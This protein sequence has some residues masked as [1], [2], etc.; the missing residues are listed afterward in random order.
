M[1][2]WWDGT[3]GDAAHIFGRPQLLVKLRSCDFFHQL[4]QIYDM[5]VP[6]TWSLSPTEEDGKTLAIP[7]VLPP[8]PQ[9]NEAA[10]PAAPFVSAPDGAATVGHKVTFVPIKLTVTD[11]PPIGPF[12]ERE[13]SN[14]PLLGALDWPEHT[15]SENMTATYVPITP[16]IRWTNMNYCDRLENPQDESRLGHHHYFNEA[17]Q[18][19]FIDHLQL[20]GDET[21]LAEAKAMTYVP[22]ADTAFI[23]AMDPGLRGEDERRDPDGSA[24]LFGQGPTK[25]T[26]YW[27]EAKDY[28][29]S[30]LPQPL[31]GERSR[32]AIIGADMLCLGPTSTPE[33]NIKMM[34]EDTHTLHPDEFVAIRYGQIEDIRDVLMQIMERYTRII[35]ISEPDG[36]ADVTQKT[37][38][39]PGA[40]VIVLGCHDLM[41]SDYWRQ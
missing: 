18:R 8:P 35:S 38:I 7:L 5:E 26:K 16:D 32:L 25:L 23:V 10:P 19:C 33:P 41:P 6:V 29:I 31:T 37:P 11:R 30:A 9:E 13:C 20:M 17:W 40:M 3:G 2:G 24:P 14:T 15:P 12:A 34:L 1:R 39:Y 36:L 22:G 28:V 27:P 21:N 4:H